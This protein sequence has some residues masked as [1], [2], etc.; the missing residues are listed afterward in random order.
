MR[1]PIFG[2]NLTIM[3]GVQLIQVIEF[4]REIDPGII[5]VMKVAKQVT[6]RKHVQ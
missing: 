5:D 6:Q 1:C 2:G 3:K 4:G